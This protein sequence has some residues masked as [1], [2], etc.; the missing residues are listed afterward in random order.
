MKLYYSNTSPYSRKVRLVIKMKGLDK[1]VEDILI[2]PFEDKAKLKAI[3]PL[4]KIPA[5]VLENNEVLF[6]SPV[7]C[8]YLDSL[9]EDK[10]LIPRKGWQ[11][12]LVL[13]WEALADG[14]TD[15]AYNIVVERRRPASEQ[16]ISSISQWAE[17]IQ[18][19]LHE[20]EI[21]LE[22]LDGETTL[23]HLAVG[24]AIGYLDF[25]LP[26]LLYESNCP[27]VAIR[28]QLISWYETFKTHPP[29]LTTRLS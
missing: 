12:W 28:P 3:N 24:A 14:L 13:R 19:V 18:Q 11:K 29:M 16:S 22:E 6:D 20:M 1:Q 23:A 4:G 5:L 8:H 9:S 17:E 25:R 21:R 7:I 26:E 27:Q 2:N 10:P 15:A